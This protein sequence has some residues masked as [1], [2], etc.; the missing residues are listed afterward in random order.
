MNVDQKIDNTVRVTVF[1]IVPRDEFNK[2][3]VQ[4]NTGSG[5]EDGRVGVAGEIGGD[6]F[7]FGVAEDTAHRAFGG[8]FE[9]GFDF[10]VRGLFG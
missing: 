3:G 4:G 5:I 7:V 2:V 10:V 6:D 9:G 8:G 1:V